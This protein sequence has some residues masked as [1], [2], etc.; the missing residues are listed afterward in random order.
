MLKKITL[1]IMSIIILAGLYIGYSV[2][3]SRSGESYYLQLRYIPKCKPIEGGE[4]DCTYNEV[5]FNSKG[6]KKDVEFF[7]IKSRP[8]KKGAYLEVI[9]N[10]ER[11][12]VTYREVNKKDI[13]KSALEK[14]ESD[15]K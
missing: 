15:K 13:P 11:G 10:D 1:G 3:E 9:V 7:S 12:V 8:L 4:L 2:H 14:L 5:S 6:D